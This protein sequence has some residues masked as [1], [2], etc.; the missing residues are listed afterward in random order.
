LITG[1][2][3]WLIPVQEITLPITLINPA[4]ISVAIAT[5]ALHYFTE[6]SFMRSVNIM[7]LVLPVVVMIR[8]IVEGVI[9][10]TSHNLW[11]FELIIAV[12][13]GYSV[14]LPSAFAGL[15]LRKLFHRPKIKSDF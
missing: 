1:I 11:P 15:L 7:A 14:S 2:P 13:L 4:L 5:I 3:Y 12:I 6:N 10:P 8:V 9:D